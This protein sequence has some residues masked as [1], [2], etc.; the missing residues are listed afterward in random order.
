M[1]LLHIK[2]RGWNIYEIYASNA[3]EISD[4]HNCEAFRIVVNIDC[5]FAQKCNKSKWWYS[6]WRR[7]VML[8]LLILFGFPFGE[9]LVLKDFIA[10]NTNTHNKIHDLHLIF[11]L[12]YRKISSEEQNDIFLYFITELE[13]SIWMVK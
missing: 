9:L 6:K 10:C 8:I 11:H 7:Y 5:A 4:N 3:E 13:S 2:W 12:K 1:I